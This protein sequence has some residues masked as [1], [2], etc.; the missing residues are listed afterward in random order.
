MIIIQQQSFVPRFPQHELPQ[1]IPP[2]FPQ[3]VRRIIIQRIELQFPFPSPHPILVLPH[4]QEE[5]HSHLAPHP[6]LFSHSFSHPHPQ[7]VAAK[8]LILLPPNFIYSSSYVTS[9]KCVTGKYVDSVKKV[10]Y[11][12]LNGVTKM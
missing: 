1:P 8:S 5:P 11:N 7:F 3:N 2:L 9:V 4:P 12:K 6:H 10:I